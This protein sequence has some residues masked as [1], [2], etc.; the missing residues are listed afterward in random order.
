M[1]HFRSKRLLEAARLLP[2]QHCGRDDGTVVAAHSNQLVHG[3]G[4]AL[5]AHDCFIAA[6]C[7]VCHSALDQGKDMSKLERREFWQ[8]AHN[9]TMLE[10]FQRRIVGTK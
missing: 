6:L 2:C 3:K 5:K 10:F 8:M 1:G 7:A 9:K 4:G